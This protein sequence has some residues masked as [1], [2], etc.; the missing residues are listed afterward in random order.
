MRKELRTQSNEY[1]EFYNINPKGRLVCDCVVRSIALA[2]GQSWETTLREMTELGIKKGT[3]LNDPK[4][5][6][7]YLAQKGFIKSNEP[8]DINN[9]KMTVREWMR[10]QQIYDGNQKATIVAKI[11]S[12]HLSCIVDGKVH[13][14]WDCSNRTM[15]AFWYRFK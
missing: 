10:E 15:H 13:D 12:H 5:Y 11:G 9:R 7:L 8:R 2:C 1:Y 3:V 6:P 14:I 4:L